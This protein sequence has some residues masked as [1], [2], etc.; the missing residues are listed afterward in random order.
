[1]WDREGVRN[2]V[3]YR[4]NNVKAILIAYKRDYY[5]RHFQTL[6]LS[7]LAIHVLF[8]NYWCFKCHNIGIISHWCQIKS[9]GF[10]F[11]ELLFKSSTF[12]NFLIPFNIIVPPSVSLHIVTTLLKL[13]RHLLSIKYY[14]FSVLCLLYTC[15]FHGISSQTKIMIF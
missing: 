9:R 4:G 2:W 3:C 10:V 11:Y 5:T 8:R 6:I 1:M 7:P 15:S 13:C 12:N 14:F